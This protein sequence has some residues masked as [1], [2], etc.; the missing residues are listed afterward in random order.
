M[1]QGPQFYPILGPIFIEYRPAINKLSHSDLLQSK[2]THKAPLGLLDFAAGVANATVLPVRA[3][4]VVGDS[5]E[6]T[7]HVHSTSC[8]G[9]LATGTA[10][11]TR[12]HDDGGLKGTAG[13][14]ERGCR[15]PTTAA[16]GSQTRA[17]AIS[18]IFRFSVLCMR[19]H[20]PS[21][22]I[23]LDDERSNGCIRN[24]IF[25][26]LLAVFTAASTLFVVVVAT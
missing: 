7:L 21:I 12:A 18:D 17:K 8:P 15:M 16:A 13:E 10:L 20:D 4:V 5:P 22:S 3:A 25:G 24:D 19:D 23:Q 26:E 11:T 14:N 1:G 2:H 6:G 9:G